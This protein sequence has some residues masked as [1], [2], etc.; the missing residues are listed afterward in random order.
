MA[1]LPRSHRARRRLGWAALG[2]AVV[3]A[4]AVG[5]ALLPSADPA[6]DT[7]VVGSEQTETARPALRLTPARRAEIDRLVRSFTESAVTREDPAAAWAL[8]SQTMRRGVPR[9]TWDRGELPG[10]TPFP[11]AALQDV[12]WS[13]AYRAPDRVG[14]DVLVVARPGTGQRSLVYQVDLVLEQGRLLV[15]TWT[16]EATL[17]AGGSSPPPADATAPPAAFDRGR[18]DATWL[19]VPA[20][21]LVVLLGTAAILLARHALRSRRAYR[22]YRGH[23]GT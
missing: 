5:I 17:T 12:S 4:V 15:E 18:L 8:A 23:A 14:L 2:A 11:A 7:A 3:A 22:R 16:P 1:L 10:V 19:L 13:V 6:P 21:I 9:E 20:G